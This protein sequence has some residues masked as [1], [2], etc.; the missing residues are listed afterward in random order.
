MGRAAGL[1]QDQANIRGVFVFRFESADALDWPSQPVMRTAGGKVRVIYCLDMSK[2]S[3]FFAAKSF[4]VCDGDLIYTAHAPT[5]GLQKLLGV[6]GSVVSPGLS[7]A[8]N[9]ANIV[10]VASP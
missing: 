3:S 2:P 5:V 8:A 9:T 7:G 4:P 10:N 6:V 1:N